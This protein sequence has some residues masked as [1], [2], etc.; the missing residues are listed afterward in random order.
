MEPMRNGGQAQPDYSDLQVVNHGPD[1]S[2]L[3]AVNHGPDAPEAVLSNS[4]PE[5]V[6]VEHKTPRYAQAP[7]IAYSD[8][9]D[10]PEWSGVHKAE[11]AS[12]APAG[13]KQPW[14]KRKR[15]MVAIAVLILIIVGAV[16]GAVVATR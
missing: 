10:A 11:E 14:W 12:V 8:G 5:A 9:E 6:P 15:W 3:Q 2:G 4:L 16:V 13:H 7:L 1:Y